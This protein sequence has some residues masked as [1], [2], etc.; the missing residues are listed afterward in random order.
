MLHAYSTLDFP[1]DG[2]DT[3]LF[4]QQNTATGERLRS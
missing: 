4:V 3:V 2:G 1:T